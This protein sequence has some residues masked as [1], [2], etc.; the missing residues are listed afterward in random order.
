M[1]LTEPGVPFTA[2][3][4]VPHLC[5][6]GIPQG[7]T[8]FPSG[9]EPIGSVSRGGQ[10]V[11]ELSADQYALWL[12]L[13]QPKQ[14][15]QALETGARLGLSRPE[16]DLAVLRQLDLVVDFTPSG[17]LEVHV[18]RLRAVPTAIS[19][20]NSAEQPDLYAIGHRLEQPEIAVGALEMALWT[21]FNGAW[22]LQDVVVEVA[23]RFSLPGVALGRAVTALV[24]QA[25]TARIMLLDAPAPVIK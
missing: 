2:P 22:S 14:H 7:W 20:G 17:P 23:E 11:D 8:V 1:S 25:M 19:L 12:L 6:I 21:C 10:L 24:F 15:Q 4:A 16:S 13:L 9:E 3:P 18:G 5:G